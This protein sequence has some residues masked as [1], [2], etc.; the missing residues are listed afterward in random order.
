MSASLH[1]VQMKLDPAALIRFATDQKLNLRLD[2]DSGYAL[3]AWLVAMFGTD[4]PKPFRWFE[5]KAELLGYTACDRNALAERAQMFA[6][7]IA[8]AALLPDGLHSKAMPQLLAEKCRLAVEVLAC[9]VSRKDGAEKDIY[10]RELDR[11]DD[12]ARPRETVYLDW[13]R[14]Q[15]AGAV[16]FE[17]LTLRGFTRDRTLRRGRSEHGRTSRMLERPSALFAG[18]GE[19]HDSERFGVLLRRGIG[20]HRAFGYGM[21]LLAPER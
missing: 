21:V 2:R 19:V 16:A 8:H 11:H 17:T 4:A 18:V 9:P 13:F 1:L 20:R 12:T 14:K 10:L 3:H 7:P 6:S 5:R 15:W